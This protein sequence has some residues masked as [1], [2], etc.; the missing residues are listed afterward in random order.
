MTQHGKSVDQL[1]GALSFMRTGSASVNSV[2]GVNEDD[3]GSDYLFARAQGRTQ[4]RRRLGVSSALLHLASL[5]WAFFL[6]TYSRLPLALY[7]SCFWDRFPCLLASPWHKPSAGRKRQATCYER[8]FFASLECGVWL[9]P[10]VR[11][12]TLL[13]SLTSRLSAVGDGRDV[14][15]SF[16]S[17]RARLGMTCCPRVTAVH[18]C[19]F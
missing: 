14:L 7:I 8:R 19:P 12:A 1:F 6:V 3:G 17:L 11:R 10:R 16:F 9:T 15:M 13:G 2:V 4:A 5:A 18:T